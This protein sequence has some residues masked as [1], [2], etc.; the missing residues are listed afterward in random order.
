[1]NEHFDTLCLLCSPN[2]SPDDLTQRTIDWQAIWQLAVRHRVVPV[3][4][5]TMRQLGIQPP[6]DIAQRMAV[7]NKENVLKGMK[8]SAELVL[9]THL[10][11]AH[12]IPF[13]AFKGLAFNHLAGIEL[14]QRHTGDM[15]ILLAQID[16]LSRTDQ[17]LQTQGYQRKTPSA[18]MIFNAPQQKHFLTYGK[19]M[20]YWHPQKKINLEL[21]FKLT[22]NSLLFPVSPA[23]LYANRSHINIGETSIP[24]MSKTDHLLYLLVHGAVSRWFRLKWLSDIPLISRNGQHYEAPT[25][26]TRAQ[27]LGVERMVMQGLWLAHEQLGMPIPATILTQH[28]RNA[29]TKKLVQLAKQHQ[30]GAEPLQRRFRG[31]VSRLGFMLSTDF[32]YAWLLRHEVRYKVNQVAVY[33][34]H[35][36][37]WDTLRL[38]AALFWLYYPLR[39]LLWLKRQF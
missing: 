3:M 9:L 18:G 31:V 30:R 32:W 5:D 28:K 29:A 15:D 17:L 7:H 26:L 14:H 20:T 33:L 6:A 8:Q 1:M 16:D 21:H 24:V 13:L 11:Q 10:F 38:P 19:D 4:T 39:P 34:T 35:F 2:T 36:M 23:E 25:F 37:D 12:N 22:N 27:Y